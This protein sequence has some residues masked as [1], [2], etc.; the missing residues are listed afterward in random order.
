ME[1]TWRWKFDSGRVTPY[2]HLTPYFPPFH[3]VSTALYPPPSPEESIITPHLST[4]SGRAHG[5]AEYL[6]STL[7]IRPRYYQ[8][9]AGSLKKK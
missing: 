9:G 5:G 6:P 4:S 2:F 1:C 7:E 3:F 8:L